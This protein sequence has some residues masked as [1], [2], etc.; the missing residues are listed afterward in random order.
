MWSYLHFRKLLGCNTEIRI[1]WTPQVRGRPGGRQME[2][3]RVVRAA[4]GIWR[5]RQQS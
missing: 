2:V 1:G 4:R 5:E 3:G